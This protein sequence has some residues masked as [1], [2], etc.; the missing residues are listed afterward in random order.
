MTYLY[1]ILQATK[2]YERAVQLNWNSPQV[3]KQ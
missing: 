3:C 1:F 2:N